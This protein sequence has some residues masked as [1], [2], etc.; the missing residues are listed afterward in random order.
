M[1]TNIDIDDLQYEL[2]LLLGA[3]KIASIL[4][5]T[6]SGNVINYAKDSV[7]LHARNLYNFFSGNATNDARVKQFTDHSFD[8]T[9]YNLWIGAL[10]DHVLHIKTKRSHNVSNVINGVHLNEKTQDFADD[11][12]KMWTEWRD[13]T[14]DPV[15]RVRLTDALDVA[16]K[17]AEDDFDFLSK[18]LES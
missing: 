9:T 2:R 16:Q 7:Y 14:L 11:I 1:T 13:A 18:K 15:F 8:L 3:A 6:A 5:K 10:H 12:K 4:E 17:E